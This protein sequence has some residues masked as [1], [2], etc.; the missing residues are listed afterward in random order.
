MKITNASNNYA[1]M[2]ELGQRI[3]DI[4]IA[5]N[6]TQAEFANSSG[7]S[8]RTLTRLENGENVKMDVLCNAI[9][10]LGFCENF[11]LLLQE[12]T[13]SPVQIFDGQTKKRQRVKQNK[14]QNEKIFK[15]G[16]DI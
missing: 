12:Q 1:I 4:R 13:L 14:N 8:L 5:R 11:E 6:I 16:D 7:I 2:K 15:W 3:K 10:T 9:R